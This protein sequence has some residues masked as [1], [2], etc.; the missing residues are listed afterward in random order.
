MNILVLDAM[1]VI[2]MAG[3][4]VAE[5]LCPFVHENGGIADNGRIEALPTC[6]AIASR[7]VWSSFWA[8]PNPEHPQSGVCPMTFQSGLASCGNDS[9]FTTL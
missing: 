8:K 5:L 1:G 4:D 6:S 9:S 3:D 7:M 2:Y